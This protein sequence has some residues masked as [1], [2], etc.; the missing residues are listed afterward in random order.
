MSIGMGLE[1]KDGL[2]RLEMLEATSMAPMPD[3]LVYDSHY[4][5][6][7]SGRHLIEQ[8]RK[9]YGHTLIGRIWYMGQIIGQSGVPL[10]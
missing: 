5:A 3:V 6:M 4:A 2:Y 7:E 8:F 1:A 9:E 10:N